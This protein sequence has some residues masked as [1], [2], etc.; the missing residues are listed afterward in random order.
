MEKRNYSWVSLAVVGSKRLQ[1]ETRSNRWSQ[2]CASGASLQYLKP[3]AAAE[4][5]ALSVL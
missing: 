5:P 3:E 1:D 4:W 2:K